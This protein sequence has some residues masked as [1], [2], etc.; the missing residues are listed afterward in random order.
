ML[1]S[2]NTDAPGGTFTDVAVGWQHSCG[3][4]TDGTITCWGF[5]Y[6]GELEPPDGEFAAVFC[7]AWH[8]CG[9]GT[10]GTITCWGLSALKTA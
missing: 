1:G 3:V 7:G 6:D 9:L 2:G 8:A 4:R 5:D 10:D